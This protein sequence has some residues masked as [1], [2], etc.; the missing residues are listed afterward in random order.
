MWRRNRTVTR[1]VA[2][3]VL[4]LIATTPGQAS[5]E[6]DGY[7]D[8]AAA[9]GGYFGVTYFQDGYFSETVCGVGGGAAV[10]P[11]KVSVGIPR[12]GM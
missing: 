11:P 7:F 6:C 5:L 8:G 1:L 12:L 4:T 2:A 9:P 10:R 3:T